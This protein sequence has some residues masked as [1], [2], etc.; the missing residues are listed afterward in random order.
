V[1]LVDLY[2][3]VGGKDRA[4]AIAHSGEQADVLIIAART[5]AELAAGLMD[6]AIATYR[7]WLADHPG[8]TQVASTLAEYDLAARRF[9]EARA[10]SKALVKK[11][12]TDRIA[13]NNLAWLYQQA[14][15][16]RARRLAERAYLVAPD[17]PQTVDT[18]AW[19]L[20]PAIR[21][22]LA[23][24]LNDNGYRDEAIRLLTSLTAERAIFDDK[25]AAEKLL[26]ELSQH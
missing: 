19:I 21:Y 5:R 11:R 15:D 17:L 23:V 25:S 20:E 22:H 6:A 12:P 10:V 1:A 18:L 3:R 24:A 16:P 4:L 26:V 14:G 13:L 9:D 8:D 7:Q 2:L